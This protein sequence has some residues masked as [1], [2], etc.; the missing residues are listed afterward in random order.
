LAAEAGAVWLLEKPIMLPVS[1]DVLNQ[2]RTVKL[3]G[4]LY[5]PMVSAQPVV[6]FVVIAWLESGPEAW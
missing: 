3:S 6:P 2:A 1:E 4:L 5:C